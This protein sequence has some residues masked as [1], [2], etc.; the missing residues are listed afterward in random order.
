MFFFTNQKS[1]Q[2]SNRIELCVQPGSL[3]YLEQ[4]EEQYRLHIDLVVGKVSP[5]EVWV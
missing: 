3:T 1:H 2:C 4:T 5:K